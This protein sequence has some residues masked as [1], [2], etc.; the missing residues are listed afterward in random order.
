MD[1]E[2]R[3]LARSAAAAA[4]AAVL[5]YLPAARFGYV[6]DDQPLIVTNPAAHGVVAALRAFDRPFWPEE[7]GAGM[8][9]PITV[10]SYGVDWS[11]SG[12]RLGWLHCTNALWHGLACALVVLV[13]ARWLP[14]AGALAAGL[15]FAV[16]PVHVEGVANLASRSEL[17]TACGLLATVLAARRRRWAAALLCA[18]L[19]LLSKERGVVTG[20]V[21][22]LDDWLR[23]PGESAYPRWFYGALGA[24][25]AASLGG[26]LLIGRGTGVDVAPAFIT[27]NA[28]GRLAMAFPALWRGA[29]LLMWPSSLS[30]DYG[31][32]VI[33]YRSSITLAAICGAALMLLVLLASLVVKRRAPA[34]SFAALSAA[35]TH[36]PTA[37]LLFASGIVLAERDLYLPVLLPATLVG[38]GVTWALGRWNRRR[39]WLTTGV[40]AAGLATRSLYRLP[41]WTDNGAFLLTLLTEHPESYRGHQYLAGVLALRGRG[42]EARRQ[43]ATADSLFARDPHLKA[44]FASFLISQGDSAAA[45]RLARDARRLLPRERVALRVEYLLAR[46]RGEREAAAA[47]AD[48]AQRWFPFERAWYSGTP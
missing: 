41:A 7:V 36:L 34:L 3:L 6:E 19:A 29:G 30:A 8:Y 14:P 39:V 44:E 17:L 27:T 16:H 9:R 38:A 5:L 23:P 45:A 46:S 40:L 18:A 10:L 42:A 15:V 31:P 37:N 21:V 1:R 12:G 13:L 20:A 11:L 25:T 47:L 32:Q 35:L 28:G 26:W 33:P 4:L 2:R 43:Y 48:T 22:L 24:L